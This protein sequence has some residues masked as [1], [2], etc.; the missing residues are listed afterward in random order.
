MAQIKRFLSRKGLWLDL[1]GVQYVVLL[2]CCATIN[3]LPRDSWQCKSSQ[4]AHPIALDVI[5]FSGRF[6]SST[7][8][9]ESASLTCNCVFDLV[10]RVLHLQLLNHI[11]RTI[12]IYFIVL[13]G[14]T[15]CQRLRIHTVFNE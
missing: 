7:E 3:C 15:H 10:A 6:P 13:N 4:P 9:G 2:L 1:T 14:Q 11:L 5:E 8:A 12:S